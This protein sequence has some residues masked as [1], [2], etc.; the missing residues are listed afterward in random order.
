MDKSGG[1]AEGPAGETGTGP[2]L[3]GKPPPPEATAKAS[4]EGWPPGEAFTSPALP[5]KPPPRRQ[6]G[7][8]TPVSSLSSSGNT[9]EP[10]DASRVPLRYCR[11][12]KKTQQMQIK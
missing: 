8:G 10:L 11:N 2:T 6:L 4:G 5:G 12:T 9:A 7:L 3:P 1:V